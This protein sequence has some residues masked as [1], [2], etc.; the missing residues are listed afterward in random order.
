MNFAI[1][2]LKELYPDKIIKNISQY[3]DLYYSLTCEAASLNKSLKEYVSEAGYIYGNDATI[4]SLETEVE[5]A[6]RK[7]GQPVL[8]ASLLNQNHIYSNIARIASFYGIT[9]RTYIEELG[10]K[11]VKIATNESNIDYDTSKRLKEKFS[12]TLEEI[13]TIA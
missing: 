6:L 2:T 13:G 11:Y 5:E 9:I 4:L 12:F 8:N 3:K 10:Y 7:L 1:E